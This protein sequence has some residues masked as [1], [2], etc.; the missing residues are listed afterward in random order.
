MIASAARRSTRGMVARRS[1]ASAKGAMSRSIS[2]ERHGLGCTKTNRRRR[3][4]TLQR[5]PNHQVGR[6]T[7]LR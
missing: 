1:R 7:P 5:F 6:Q 4:A 3:R 2:A